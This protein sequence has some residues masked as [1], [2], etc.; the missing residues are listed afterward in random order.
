MPKSGRRSKTHAQP[1]QRP[2]AAVAR[3]APA[4]PSLPN[5]AAVANKPL[6]SWLAQQGVGPFVHSEVVT[7]LQNA[8][9][10]EPEWLGELQGMGADGSLPHF[11]GTVRA[12]LATRLAAREQSF[13]REAAAVRLE[14]GGSGEGAGGVAV[15]IAAALAL[16]YL[17]GLLAVDAVFDTHGWVL[18]GAKGQVT[19]AAYSYYCTLLPSLFRWPQLLRVAIP[20]L[21]AGL[22]LIRS[23]WR[24]LADGD[25][26]QRW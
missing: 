20:V 25:T 23:S 7:A 8:G 19:A 18:A 15:P 1:P 10:P 12:A 16:A 21:G 14:L 17:L 2:P 5:G 26:S 9:I 3:S 22:P 24:A 13:Q 4:A 11:L 6:A